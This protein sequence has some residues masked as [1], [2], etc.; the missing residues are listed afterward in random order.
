MCESGNKFEPI[1]TRK[2]N[3]V[4]GIEGEI[5]DVDGEITGPKLPTG[6]QVLR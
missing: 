1:Q 2:I 5:T 3:A 4:F 6:D